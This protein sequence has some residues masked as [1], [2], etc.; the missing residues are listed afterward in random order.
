MK[1]F[2]YAALLG[3]ISAEGVAANSILENDET[4]L[5]KFSVSA[6]DGKEIDKLWKDVGASW[7]GL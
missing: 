7:N 3:L 4:E 5:L 1:F 2:T 6:K